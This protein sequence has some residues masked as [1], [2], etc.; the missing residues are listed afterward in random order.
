MRK[1]KITADHSKVLTNRLYR[2]FRFYWATRYSNT[3]PPQKKKRS[4]N[5]QNKTVKTALVPKSG[6]NLPRPGGGGGHFHYVHIG[7]VPF[8]RP[9]LSPLNFRSRAYNFHRLTEKV[10]P[11]HHHF[12]VFAAAETIIFEIYLQAVRRRPRPVYCGQ[13]ERE[14]FGERSGVI[15]GQNAARRVLPFSR[16]SPLQ[17]PTFSRSRPLAPA[18]ARISLRRGTYLPNCGSSASPP[19]P[20]QACA[21]V[22]ILFLQFIIVLYINVTEDHGIWSLEHGRIYEYCILEMGNRGL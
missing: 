3:P 20:P 7:Y 21:T 10:A 9:P 13:S 1:G 18:R 19:P 6:S 16:W 22:A 11:E 15:V 8:L 17:R 2:L 12:R 14:V 5:Q 4:K